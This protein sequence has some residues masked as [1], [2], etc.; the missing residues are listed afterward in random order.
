MSAYG[1][2][3]TNWDNGNSNLKAKIALHRDA[4]TTGNITDKFIQNGLIETDAIVNTQTMVG[5]TSGTLKTE[6]I[7]VPFEHIKYDSE[8]DSYESISGIHM[9]M[10]ANHIDGSSA[11][12]VFWSDLSTI[13]RVL[14]SS[15]S[16]IS[17]T[18]GSCCFCSSTTNELQ[19]DCIDYVTEE[20]CNN[21]NGKFNSTSICANR[22]EGPD[23]N[24]AGACCVNDLCV[25]S[26]RDKCELF[27]GFFIENLSCE[28]VEDLEGCP[29]NCVEN[30]ARG[31][32]CVNNVCYELTEYECSFEPNSIFFEDPC[33]QVNCCLEAQYGACCIDETCYETTPQ[34]CNSL[35]D[36]NGNPGIFWG[37]NSSCAGPEGN[38]SSQGTFG[39]Y[40]P[41]DCIDANTG[42]I[43]P[44]SGIDSNGNCPDGNAPPCTPCLGWTLQNFDGECADGNVCAC[45]EFG[46]KPC[47]D[48]VYENENYGC[49]IC[50]GE[51]L[52]CGSIVLS[53]G[54][55]W[56]C[57]C[58]SE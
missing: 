10:T 17:S 34:I 23:C 44:D 3:N 43:I 49:T 18:F 31:A 48:C 40:A 41:F 19:S 46:G 11:G 38:W 54:T 15:N 47:A 13:D 6:G 5:S 21:I 45:G 37:V 56:R 4:K 29:D 39:V 33:D 35:T 27:G 55:C 24:V 30:G 36:A 26:S 28:D 50:G 51:T 42:E 22:P 7:A 58:G 52:S 14:S 32:C 53:D 12:I 9:G 2:L 8:S 1:A 25:E 20:Y 57:C 16:D